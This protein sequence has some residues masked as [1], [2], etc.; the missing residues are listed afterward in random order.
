MFAFSNDLLHCY[1]TGWRY[2]DDRHV[3][4][5]SEERVVLK[6]AYVLFYKRRPGVAGLTKQP[7]AQEITPQPVETRKAS[8]EDVDE[9][10]LD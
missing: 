4:K 3:T 7:T 8:L 1:S 6:Y 2:F 10:E 9:N 5:T